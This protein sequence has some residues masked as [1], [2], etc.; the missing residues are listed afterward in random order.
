MS[1][2]P[3]HIHRKSGHLV[4]PQGYRKRA[5]RPLPEGYW[6][7]HDR[8]E[9]VRAIKSAAARRIDAIS[10]AWRQL[11]DM[12]EPTETGAARFA[13]LDAV[14]AWSNELEQKA[15]SA[16]TEDALNAVLRLVEKGP[17]T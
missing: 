7:E 9:L 3:T 11:N 8:R 14:R 15:L 17:L 12:R 5:L 10:P 16:P 4:F 13:A 6:L 1:G 2:R